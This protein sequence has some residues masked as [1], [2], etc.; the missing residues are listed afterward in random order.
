MKATKFTKARAIVR[1]T[2]EEL[3]VDCDKRKINSY[4]IQ[5]IEEIN[6]IAGA[7]RLLLEANGKGLE[8]KGDHKLCQNYREED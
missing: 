4:T 5:L 8:I 3:F 1:K 6:S 2:V 7:A